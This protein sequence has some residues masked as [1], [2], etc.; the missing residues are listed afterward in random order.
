[1][2]ALTRA[3]SD[4]A[5]EVLGVRGVELQEPL[6]TELPANTLRIDRAWRMQDGRIFHL[7][8]QS[9]REPTLHRFF[10]YDVRLARAYKANVRTVVLYHGGI[11][12]VPEELSIGVAV[13]RVEN[14]YLS[15]LDG[16]EALAAVER[17]LQAGMWEPGD[18]LRLALAM[19]M[20]VRDEGQ[21]FERVLALIPA[22]PDETERDLVVSA[23][24]ALGDQTLDEAQRTRLKRELRKVSKIVEELYQE[25]QQEG[26]EQE[27][28]EVARNL[29][30]EGVSIDVIAKV[31]R[32]SREEIEQMKQMQ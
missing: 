30:A 28:R 21:A 3:L 6:P 9:T 8:F 13:Y 31:T 10:E 20:H 7:E 27:R 32:L 15:K 5:L 29:L 19:N 12:S 4:G 24:L 25:G 1:M 16:D 26:R 11:T 23:I 2:K 17:H 18:R 22:V 14:V